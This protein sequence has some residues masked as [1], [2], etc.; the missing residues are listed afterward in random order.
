M[1]G[2]LGDNP[3]ARKK[4]TGA[5]VVRVMYKRVKGGGR[6]AS[7]PKLKVKPKAKPVKKKVKVSKKRG[8]R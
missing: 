3:L 7:K 1:S 2:R 5:H 8:K 4:K 6:K